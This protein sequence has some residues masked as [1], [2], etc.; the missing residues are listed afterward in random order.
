MAHLVIG[1]NSVLTEIV[2]PELELTS[3]IHIFENP[4]MTTIDLE[5]WFPALNSVDSV[6][7]TGQFS[8]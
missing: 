4:R 1:N 5:D 6:N 2:F 7:I 8:R 3:S